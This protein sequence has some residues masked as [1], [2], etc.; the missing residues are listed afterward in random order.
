MSSSA[1]SLDTCRI[2]M[3]DID[4]D[5][6]E[7]DLNPSQVQPDIEQ[8]TQNM[9]DNEDADSKKS[10]ATHLGKLEYS[11]DYDF[12]KQEVCLPREM[13]RARMLCCRC[14]LSSLKWKLFK[15]RN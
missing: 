3:R 2:T 4:D 13:R 14:S 12:Q 6:L 11:I 9:E 15:R 5:F 8:L 10:E 1:F 7:I